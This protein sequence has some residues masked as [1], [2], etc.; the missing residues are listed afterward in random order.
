MLTLKY[1]RKPEN[2][3]WPGFV[4]ALASLLMVIIFVLM[5]FVI[6]QFYVSQKL[7]NKDEALIKMEAEIFEL[8]NLLSI[9]RKVTSKLS[10][11]LTNLEKKYETNKI[12][13]LHKEKLLQ[14]HLNDLNIKNSEVKKL[15]EELVKKKNIIVNLQ[16]EL[17]RRNEDSKT[18]KSVFKQKE[19][20]LLASKEE[21]KKLLLSTENLKQK[22]NKLKSLLM[23]YQ[24]KDK[25]EKIKNINLGKNLN[26]A[27]ARRVEELQKFKSEF[28]GRVKEKIKN[29]PEI[30][31]VGDRFVF[32]SEVLFQIGSANIG[33][34]GETEL[35]RLASILLEIEKT[36]PKDINWILQIEG[37]T[38]S[39]PVKKG[40]LFLDNWELSAQ[41]ALS[42]LRFF[43][44]Q[45]L[46]PKR[47]SASGYGSFQPLIKETK[48]SDRA[49]NRR[50]EMK[51]TQKLNLND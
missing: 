39:L 17:K 36:I 27:L 13:L 46:N 9:E 51:I 12:D 47:L 40:Q 19:T 28:F 11:D 6:A 31:I 20:E 15:E 8:N 23:V 4:D 22:I 41:R 1:N 35:E 30:K 24:A 5:T 44:K 32:Q 49:K 14:K 48:S 18:Q 21:I 33:K 2:Y 50:I 37:H 34:K 10:M 29:R 25:K 42:V 45:G 7:S 38:D 26:T 3:T 43:V 16:T